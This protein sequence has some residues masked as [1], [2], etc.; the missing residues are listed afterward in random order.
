MSKFIIIAQEEGND[1]PYTVD[2]AT[3]A[4]VEEVLARRRTFIEEL[5]DEDYAATSAN[6]DFGN[7]IHQEATI[8][9]HGCTLV[10]AEIHRVAC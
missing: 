7:G 1:R 3:F 6:V 5:F 9:N 10:W 2:S 4:T 8:S